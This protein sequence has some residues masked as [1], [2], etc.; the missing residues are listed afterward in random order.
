MTVHVYVRVSTKHQPDSARRQAE[1]CLAFAEQAGYP[2][3]VIYSDIGFSGAKT[4][5]QRPA[6]KALTESLKPRDVVIY[7]AR[8]RLA[9]NVAVAKAFDE[10]CEDLMITQVC[11]QERAH[12]DAEGQASALLR[13]LVSNG[14]SLAQIASELEARGV[15]C[16]G[17]RWHK[18][19][20]P[21]EVDA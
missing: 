21:A 15:P 4:I 3:P 20:L 1:A 7:E 8:D 2:Q 10:L 19:A 12:L 13:A 5:G 9:R 6:L 14:M 17:A 16:R 18:K 11:L